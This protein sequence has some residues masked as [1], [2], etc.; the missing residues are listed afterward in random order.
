MLDYYR[1]LYQNKFTRRKEKKNF[2][3]EQKKYILLLKK[4]IEMLLKFKKKFH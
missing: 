2:D 4:D 3:F 1:L